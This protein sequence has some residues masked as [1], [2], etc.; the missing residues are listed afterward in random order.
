MGTKKNLCSIS[1]INYCDVIS[2]IEHFGMMSLVVQVRDIGFL[3]DAFDCSYLVIFHYV[4]IF[5]LIYF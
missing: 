3:E 1:Q 4:S 5:I 2:Y